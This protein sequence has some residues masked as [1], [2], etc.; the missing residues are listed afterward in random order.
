MSYRKKHIKPK[1]SRLRNRRRFYQI[2]MFW[3][4][5]LVLI[6]LIASGYFLLFFS[7]F[8]ITEVKVSGNEK[9]QADEIGVLAWKNINKNI[10]G[11]HSKSI[12]LLNSQDLNKNILK[13]FPVVE[14]VN[15]QKKWPQGVDLQVQERKLV[16]V[17][18][19][20]PNGSEQCLSMDGN[21]VVFEPFHPDKESVLIVRQPST[22]SG[23]FLGATV[24]KKSSVDAVVKIQKSLKNNFQID[25]KDA[26]VSDNLIIT[27]SLGWKAYF[28]PAS[29]ID[30][31]IT[32]MNLILKNEIP[33]SARK[34]LEYIYLQ[35]GDRAY[36]K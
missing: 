2:P 26:L 12:F 31:Q 22:G 29:D 19:H 24:V 5:V 9:I 1:I 6:M 27:T 20:A 7:K 35:Y 28:N 15:I 23:I 34:K 13:S 17:F 30:L 32:K 25:I 8:Q 14:S 21:G 4:A 10:F 33:E 16:A 18:C 3:I 11:Y 36:Y